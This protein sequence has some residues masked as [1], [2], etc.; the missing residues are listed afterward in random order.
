MSWI[1]SV[2]TTASSTRSPIPATIKPVD[3][4]VLER[5]P[6]RVETEHGAPDR[7]RENRRDDDGRAP[8]HAEGDDEHHEEHP[9]REEL[10]RK[11]ATER[12]THAG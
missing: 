6:E 11:L 7:Q 2:T 1:D 8:A 3:R 4:D 12:R 5:H 9:L 10:R